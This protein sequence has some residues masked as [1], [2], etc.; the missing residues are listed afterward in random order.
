MIDRLPG[1]GRCVVEVLS[2]SEQ[3]IKS[4]GSETPVENYLRQARI[5]FFGEVEGCTSRA[6]S[7][8]N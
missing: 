2:A 3:R 4:E 7:G 6:S 8:G 5:D 1:G